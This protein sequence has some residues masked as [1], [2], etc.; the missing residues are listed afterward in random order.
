MPVL[1]WAVDRAYLTIC[2]AVLGALVLVGLGGFGFHLTA[3]VRGPA[4]TLL[5]NLLYGP[6]V[7]APLLFANLAILAGI[8]LWALDATRSLETSPPA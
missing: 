4:G 6:P 1:V 2:A 8:G 7:L 3:A 5:E